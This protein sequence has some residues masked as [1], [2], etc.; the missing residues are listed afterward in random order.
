MLRITLQFKTHHQH[1]ENKRTAKKEYAPIAPETTTRM[2]TQSALN[3]NVLSE[4]NTGR[5][6]KL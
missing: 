6:A 4:R 1:Q 3:A 5:L 2:P